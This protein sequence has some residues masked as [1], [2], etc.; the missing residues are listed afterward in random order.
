MSRDRRMRD[1]RIVDCGHKGESSQLAYAWDGHQG[2]GC[3]PV[4]EALVILLSC[5]YRSRRP[6]PSPQFAPQSD[7]AWRQKDQLSPRLP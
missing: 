2:A 1:E 3:R 7:P 6:P 5:L 4:A